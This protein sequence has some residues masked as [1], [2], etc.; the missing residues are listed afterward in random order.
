MMGLN[1]TFLV[2][3]IGCVV[4]TVLA[5]FIGRDPAIEAAKATQ[6]RGETEETPPVP[7]M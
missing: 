6:K 1:D 7:V 2:V 3:L 4:C 5:F